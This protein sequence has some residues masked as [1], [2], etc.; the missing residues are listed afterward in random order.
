MDMGLFVSKRQNRNSAW[1]VPVL[2]TEISTTSGGYAAH[3]R[4]DLE[5]IVWCAGPQVSDEALYLSTA[6]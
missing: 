1:G 5:H 6:R 4:T 3:P 2:V